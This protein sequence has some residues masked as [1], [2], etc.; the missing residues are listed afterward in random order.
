M[1]GF[2]KI[3]RPEGLECG[4]CKKTFVTKEILIAHKRVIH[5]IPTKSDI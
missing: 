2:V 1:A 5:D 4:I 3:E